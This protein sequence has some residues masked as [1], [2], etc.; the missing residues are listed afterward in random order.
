MFNSLSVNGKLGWVQ[1]N[2]ATSTLPS[3]FSF[4]IIFAQQTPLEEIRRSRLCSMKRKEDRVWSAS[5]VIVFLFFPSFFHFLKGGLENTTLCLIFHQRK[6]YTRFMKINSIAVPIIAW[7]SF[8]SFEHN[9]KIFIKLKE[10][11]LG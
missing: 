10:K 1:C 7:Y 3:C 9:I 2:E 5:K 6:I 8:L 4:I 11:T